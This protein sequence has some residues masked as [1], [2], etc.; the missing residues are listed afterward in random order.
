MAGIGLVLFVA[1]TIVATRAAPVSEPTFSDTGM[2]GTEALQIDE[3]VFRG[4]AVIY[5]AGKGHKRSIILVHG[6]N[7]AAARVFA[8]HVQWLARSYHV[9]AVDLPGF[10]L[11]DK[12]NELY[13]PKNYAAFIK[14]VADKYVRRPFVLLGYSMGSVVSLRYAATHPDDLEQLVIV[15]SP[16]ILHRY[17]SASHYI[18]QLG[19]GFLPSAVDPVEGLA[20]LARK[21]LGSVEK[22]S[23][24]DPEVVLNS[25][26]MRERYLQ[27]DP[28]RIAGLATGVED[29]SKDVGRVRI[30]TL[31]IWG[32]KDVIAPP[33]TGRLLA[34]TLPRAQLVVI[35]NAEHTP[36]SQTPEKFRATLEPFLAHGLK[37]AAPAAVPP[38]T[39]RGVVNC[40]GKRQVVYE[41]EFDLLSLYRCHG[42]IIRNARVRELQLKNSSVTIEDSHIGGGE[43]GVV[44]HR[45]TLEMNGGRLEG[46]VA[47]LAIGSRLD[48]A[49]VEVDA[50]EAVMKAPSASEIVF[51]L[52]R[53]R[54]PNLNGDVH[55]YYA[56]GKD[57]AL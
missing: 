32:G 4:R 35:E 23:V 14:H 27:G 33:R 37:P 21:V 44:A 36:M 20:K 31:V 41:G 17:A 18:D 38:L 57:K 16:G 39:Q 28:M 29:L 42:I 43:I 19:I 2:P 52:S 12:A 56:V 30:E 22:N 6:M 15:D 9:I 48:L 34:R 1:S 54:S 7:D 49:G 47:A 53:V 11:S 55:G 10:G 45:A 25:A 46:D 8:Q 50:R 26:S 5:E 13:S 40:Q 51:S 3:P 24:A